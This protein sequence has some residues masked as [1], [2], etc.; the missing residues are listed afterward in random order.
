MSSGTPIPKPRVTPMWVPTLAGKPQYWFGLRRTKA[1]A[2]DLAR[3][4]LIAMASQWPAGARR[5]WIAL[6]KGK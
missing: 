6:D 4:G 1:E 3:N 5:V 2:V